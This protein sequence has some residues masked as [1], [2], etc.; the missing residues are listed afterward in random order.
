MSTPEGRPAAT[1]AGAAAGLVLVVVD[2]DGDN[3]LLEPLNYDVVNHRS[4]AAGYV[5]SSPISTPYPT[6]GGESKPAGR[7][8]PTGQR[9]LT[10]LA[11]QPPELPRVANNMT[12]DQRGTAPGTASS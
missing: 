5:F 11:R 3:L 9:P 8:K 1:E 12:P 10:T 6:R 7:P 2:L 4:P